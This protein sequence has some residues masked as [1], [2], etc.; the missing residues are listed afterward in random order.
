MPWLF[1][2]TSEPSLQQR[3]INRIIL[4]VAIAEPLGTIPQIVTI[5]LHHDAS[6]L[7][8]PTWIIFE[9]FN[10]LWLWY[11][12][13]ERQKAVIASAALFTILEGIVLAGALA[14]GGRWWV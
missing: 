3:M 12:L 14:Y 5:F 2:S 1:V 6:G 7:S 4:V 10:L 13:V 9:V 8:I 11:G